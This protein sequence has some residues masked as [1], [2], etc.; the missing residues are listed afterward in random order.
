[1]LFK[2]INRD[3]AEKIYIVCKNVSGGVLTAG[4]TCVFDTGASCDGVRVTQATT[5]AL[6]S[7]AG[8]ADADIANN[9]Y[10]L[11]QAWGYRSSAYIYTST[12]SSVAGDVLG[13]TNAEW[14]LTPTASTSTAPAF[15]FLCEAV[16]ASTSSRFHTTAKVFIRA[17]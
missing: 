17:L 8:V 5:A 10:G 15:G 9:G 7:V 16:A 1:M 12:G 2:R 4:Y 6:G 3:S 13:T 11:I 14:G